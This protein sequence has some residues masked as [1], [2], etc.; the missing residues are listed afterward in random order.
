MKRRNFIQI[1]CLAC[2]G[3]TAMI[4][5]LESCTTSQYVVGTLRNDVLEVKKS[6]FITIKN[7]KQIMRTFVLVKHEAYS[8]PI[9]VYKINEN[10][11]T[12]L[13]M[14]CTHQGCEINAYQ[15]QL[16]CPCHGSEFDNKGNVLQGPAD[17]PLK[18]FEVKTDD[19]N[20]YIK[21]S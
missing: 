16:V 2:L 8:F 11:Y 6:D 4:S 14:E 15:T 3:G 19:Q 10:E 1:T 12:A 7:E 21:I 13:Y 9:C 17:N 18:Q 5:I 20:I